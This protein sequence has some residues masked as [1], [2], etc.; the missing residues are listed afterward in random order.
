MVGAFLVLT[1]SNLFVGLM[2]GTER[3][4]VP[5]L[6]VTVFGL[7]S[8]V[9]ALSFIATFGV[10]KAVANL[11]SGA[12]RG[13]RQVNTL[14]L[15]WVVGLPVPLAIMYAPPDGWWIVLFANVLLGI[16]QGFCWSATVMMMIGLM[17]AARR[18]FA[19]GVNEF[20]GYGG[21]ALAAVATGWLAA[22]FG[23]RPVP[24]FIGVVAD[25]LG[26]SLSLFLRRRFLNGQP[27]GS[28]GAV[29]IRVDRTL[30]RFTWRVRGL[31][32]FHQ[33]GLV[34]N[35]KDGIVWG[36]FPLLLFTRG[37]S[38]PEIGLLVAVYPLTWG[39]VQLGSGPLSDRIGRRGP[40]A[41]GMVLQAVALIGV[42]A[43]TGFS[44]WLIS[45]IA[46][47][48]GTAFVYPTLQA[49]VADHVPG[50]DKDPALA[51]YRFWRDLG[52]AV[53]ALGGGALADATSMSATVLATAGVALV[54]G[55]I[56]AGTSGAEPPELPNP[57]IPSYRE[58]AP[59]AG[60]G[61]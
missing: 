4:L 30:A 23:P 2:V 48:L 42:V 38:L 29:S 54:A 25:I 59:I 56:V 9:A 47:G 36:L 10:T 60:S 32:P 34:T 3:T 52:F 16:N 55:A 61:P 15:G 21:V 18:G 14:L 45:M 37:A 53:G 11:F 17:P 39:T 22:S 28:K 5:L 40:I 41:F 46:L 51:T 49:A 58:Q 50:S 6:G 12:F 1:V 31:L 13:P 33:A 43:G 20:A 7:T 44:E 35:L 19:A 26:L 8:A 57:T 27:L 24:F